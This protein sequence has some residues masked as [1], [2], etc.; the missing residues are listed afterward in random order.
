MIGYLTS[1]R[2]SA[3]AALSAVLLCGAAPGKMETF[4]NHGTKLP[5]EVFEPATAGTHPAVVIAYGTDGMTNG[6]GDL[7]RSGDAIRDFA[8][9][10]TAAGY[11]VLIPDY[12]RRTGTR[13]GPEALEAATIPKNRDDWVEA[14]EDAMV[15]ADGRAGT[16]KGRVGLLGLS[17]GGHMV[18]RAGKE[19]AAVKARAVVEFAGPTKIYGLGGGLGNM[20]PLQIHHGELDNV[21][22]RDQT[23]DLDMAL[24]VAGKKKDTDYFILW[25][26]KEG[27]VP[28]KDPM[29]TDQAQR[30]TIT[31]LKKHV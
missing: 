9:K 28:F 7:P 17:L 12:F 1:R 26:M 20:P 5:I 23:D 29:A 19:A 13:P 18:L 25:Y 8:G 30:D 27:H 6:V 14:I 10:L 11:V 24:T 3:I 15:Y 22:G 31:F 4:D 16:A 2:S 21:V